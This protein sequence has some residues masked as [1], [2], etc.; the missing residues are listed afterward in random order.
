MEAHAWLRCGDTYV[1][2]APGHERFTVVSF[3]GE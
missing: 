3:F 2:G 1:T